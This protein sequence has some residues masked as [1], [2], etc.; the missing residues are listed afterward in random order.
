MQVLSFHCF[1]LIG[2]AGIM[3]DYIRTYTGIRFYP[4]APDPSQIEIR[5]I[6]HALPM[7]CRG[8]GHVS[9][10]YSVGQH[11]IFCAKEAEKLGLSP[12]IRLACLL[13]D[14]GECYLSDVPRPFKK[15]IPSYEDYEKVILQMIYEKYLGT[16]LSEKEEKWVKR[17]DDCMLAHDLKY[18]LHEEVDDLPE[19]QIDLDYDFPGFSQV[20]QEYLSCFYEIMKLMKDN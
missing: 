14:A 2:K 9:S 13:H 16:A 6:A 5:D 15:Q 10:F 12:R 3:A 18:L 17:I 1:L 8:N 11:C 19:L 20:E 7:I 4:L